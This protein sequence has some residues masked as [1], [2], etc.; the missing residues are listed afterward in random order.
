MARHCEGAG[1]AAHG[2]GLLTRLLRVQRAVLALQE[3]LMQPRLRGCRTQ[4]RT[5]HCCAGDEHAARCAS[6]CA[7]HR[8]QA[9]QQ[10]QQPR[11]PAPRLPRQPR[12]LGAADSTV[13]P[14]VA[15]IRGVFLVEE[16]V[17]AAAL[18]GTVLQGSK[19]HRRTRWVWQGCTHACTPGAALR[20]RHCCSTSATA[21]AAAA[22]R[23]A[24]P[25]AAPPEAAWS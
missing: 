17:G 18:V 11:G 12:G 14:R 20:C 23:I 25:M 5:G 16:A 9:G 2:G 7:L 15:K 21:T 24:G 22:V 3:R 19:A 1:G 4:G 13:D 10:A 6:R 8:L